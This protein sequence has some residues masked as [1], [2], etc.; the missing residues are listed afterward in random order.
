MVVQHVARAHALAQTAASALLRPAAVAGAALAPAAAALAPAARLA[1]E[2]LLLP[3]RALRQLA[4]A[5]AAACALLLTSVSAA[6]CVAC[7][8]RH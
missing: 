1:A 4:A 5:A 2:P 7:G 8:I 6:W 3:L